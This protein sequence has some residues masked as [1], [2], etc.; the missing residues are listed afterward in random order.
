MKYQ[1]RIEYLK[2]KLANVSRKIYHE[3]P[4]TNVAENLKRVVSKGKAVSQR[5]IDDQFKT[6]DKLYFENLKSFLDTMPKGNG[7]RYYEK[8]PVKIGIVADEFLINSY[9][10]A[11]D[12]I[13]LS[14]DNYEEHINEIDFL[15]VVSAWSGYN[16]EWRYMANPESRKGK[17]IIE[18]IKKVKK[19]G[20][21]TVFYSKE[22]PPH[23]YDFLH[24]AKVCDY[25]FTTEID[26]VPLYKEDCKNDNVNILQ[27]GINPA[28]HNP[29]GMRCFK[30]KNGVVFSGSW[31]RKY[32]NR[33]KFL[34]MLFSEII[35][36]GMSLKLIDRNY[37]FPYDSVKFP[38]KYIDY[39]APAVSHDYLQKVHKLYDFSININSVCTSMTMFANRVYELQA[40]GNL[41]LSNYSPGVNSQLP[42][43]FLIHNKSEIVP[44]LTSFS[45]EEIYERQIFGVRSVMTKFTSFSRI[46]GMLDVLGYN[47]DVTMRKVLVVCDKM[48]DSVKEMFERQTYPEKELISVDDFTEEKKKEFD[49][50]IFFKDGS[51]YEMFYIE[52]MVNAFKYTACDYV[53]K[54]S[55]YNGGG[56]FK[57]K[58]HN[59]V[60]I[61]KSKY[62]TAFWAEEF[63][64]SE[65]LKD[66]IYIRE[67]GYS[68]DHFNYNEVYKKSLGFEKKEYKLSVI[69]PVYNNGLHLYSKAFASLRRSSIFPDMEIIMVDDGSTD[70]GYTPN[71]IKYL[72][73]RYRNI[74][75]FFFEKGGSGSASRPR[76]K[77]VELASAEYVSF[78]DPDDEVINDSHAKFLEVIKQSDKYDCVIGNT[79][80]IAK[81][82]ANRN[83]FMQVFK[84]SHTDEISG[85]TL[86]F[87]K[88]S[89]FFS[90]NIDAGIIKRKF[91]LEN[92]LKQIE[93]AFGEDTLFSWQ[94]IKHTKGIKVLKDDF[95]VYYAAVEGSAVN[96]VS[97]KY[98]KKHF[99]I[100]KE[101][102]KFLEENDII[103]YYTNNHFFIRFE[104][105]LLGKL[106]LVTENER[107]EA[108]DIIMKIF[109]LY[110]L[111]YKDA[112][113]LTNKFV[114][115]CDDGDY[116]GA[117]KLVESKNK[118]DYRK[119]LK[120][121][122]DT[123]VKK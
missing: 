82:I 36:C 90:F 68:I 93:G 81:D 50:V 7:N 16:D 84:V 73:E 101:R 97:A 49:I 113:D 44:I 65:M 21:K 14:P 60:N 13:Y 119:N 61:I 112:S 98:Y 120:E 54:D 89:N 111:Y 10:D 109:N 23:Y 39:L 8:F 99:I 75:T 74:K 38:E 76:N 117:L 104:R 15:L 32:V 37:N 5:E 106:H 83:P 19:L 31:L 87:M 18:I 9:K 27:F 114:S 35:K 26:V 64:V 52:D 1:L 2:R 80:K 71:I 123:Y 121:W 34:D 115:L 24:I 86:E 62:R 30:K 108:I 12:F 25:I 63:S 4:K 107:D 102:I 70:N 48:S 59:Y 67:N 56:L 105:Y 91:I 28:Y 88:K 79:I 53:T 43:V 3:L 17:L 55:Y 100:E 45:K 66:G 110:R 42:L 6:Y 11:A 69:M 72:A 95:K 20:K 94:L 33:N 118:V 122:M 85:D 77:G 46:K 41:L 78:L 51:E 116:E 92:N 58:E 29:V 40:A 22:D 47:F 96:S 57:G 103:D